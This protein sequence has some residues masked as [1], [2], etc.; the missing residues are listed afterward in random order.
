MKL[1]DQIEQFFYKM[2][3]FHKEMRCAESFVKYRLDRARTYIVN[4]KKNILSLSLD[5]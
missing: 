5:Q 1:I 2:S 3:W 4:F